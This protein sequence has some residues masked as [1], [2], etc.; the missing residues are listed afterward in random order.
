M[1]P[2]PRLLE[3]CLI[4]TNNVE[5]AAII[6]SKTKNITGACNYTDSPE[7]TQKFLDAFKHL[8]ATRRR[9]LVF[10]DQLYVCVRADQHSIY[11][12]REGHGLILV[13]TSL[14]LI[15]ATY[16]EDMYPSICVEAVE[17]LGK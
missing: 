9:G 1:N 3:D 6:V 5:S 11:T 2:F 4:N 16:S 12:K 8:E 10:R 14:Y 15:V 13:K 7:Q 17:K